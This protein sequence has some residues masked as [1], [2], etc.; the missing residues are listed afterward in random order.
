[1]SLGVYLDDCA[2][3]NLLADLLRLA[4]HRAVRP[5]DFGLDGADDD[6]HLAFAAKDGFAIITKNP[7]DFENLHDFDPNHAGI[8]AVY[9]DN[10]P[11]RDMSDA[12]IVNAI[13]NLEAATQTGGEPIQGRF[14]SLNDWRY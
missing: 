6:V 12:E 2:N 3:S 14:H 4:G 9:R 11:A 8:L 1:V 13:S 10:D 5:A 7:A